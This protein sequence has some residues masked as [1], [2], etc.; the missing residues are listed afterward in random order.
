MKKGSAINYVVSV[1]GLL[2]WFL[3]LAAEAAVF[4]VHCD[5]GQHIQH[6]INLAPAGSIIHVRGTCNESVVIDETK[7]DITIDGEKTATIQGSATSTRGAT[8]DVRGR[9]IIIRNLTVRYG[10]DGIWIHH[11]ATATIN[12]STVENASNNGVSASTNAVAYIL[13]STIQNNAN[14]GISIL[15]GAAAHIGFL[16]YQDTVAQP[17]IVQNNGNNGI[18]VQRASTITVV[19]S[20]IQNNAHHGIVAL[21]NGHADIVG[22]VINGNGTNGVLV[23]DGSGVNISEIE[24][25]N[26]ALFSELN[27][28]TVPNGH[29]GVYCKQGGYVDVGA[30]IGSLNGTD[31]NIGQDGTCGM[32]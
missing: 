22:N 18:V 21:R 32:Y 27:T 13:N 10:W 14:T 17:N 19:G 11:G 8:V 16:S 12:N 15:D 23:Y 5:F 3:P 25:G 7:V 6:L 2:L 31:G 26:S 28:T 24:T 29:Y 30:N 9:E 1:F 4:T 20:T